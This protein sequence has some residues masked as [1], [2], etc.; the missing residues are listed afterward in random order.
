LWNYYQMYS[1]SSLPLRNGWLTG[2]F[3]DPFNLFSSLTS[4]EKS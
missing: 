4:F 2:G 3:T 1:T